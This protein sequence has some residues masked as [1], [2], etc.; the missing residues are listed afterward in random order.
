M[1]LPKINLEKHLVILV[2]FHFLVALFLVTGIATCLA[3][4]VTAKWYGVVFGVLS[5]A[6]GWF[7]LYQLEEKWTR[8]E[9]DQDSIT[10]TAHDANFKWVPGLK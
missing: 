6:G 10:P 7:I 1:K 2:T 9:N 3:F 4:L 8:P 5:C